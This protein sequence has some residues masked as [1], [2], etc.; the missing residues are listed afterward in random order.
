MAV[1]RQFRGDLH[2]L[3]H[4]FAVCRFRREQQ[5]QVVTALQGGLDFLRPFRAPRDAGIDEYLVPG[6]LERRGAD[7]RKSAIGF[8]M[9][10]TDEDVGGFLGRFNYQVQGGRGVG[11]GRCGILWRGFLQSILGRTSPP[12]RL[13]A[14]AAFQAPHGRIGKVLAKFDPGVVG[15]EGRQL[16]FGRA[17]QPHRDYPEVVFF[18]LATDS[19]FDFLSLPWSLAVRAHEHGTGARTGKAS[20]D[21]VDGRFAGDQPPWLEPDLE[22]R[23]VFQINGDLLDG[24]SRFTVEA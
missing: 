12:R 3:D 9:A 23:L 20:F 14:N 5:Q 8:P 21:I 2:F 18:D 24:F 4:H 7:S 10:I 15:E 11:N 1:L 6:L 22:I 17:R 16:G 19:R 13:A